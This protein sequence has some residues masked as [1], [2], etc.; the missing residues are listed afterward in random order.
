MKNRRVSLTLGFGIEEL[1]LDK[2]A[3]HRLD[4]SHCGRVGQHAVVQR[5]DA[6]E[7]NGHWDL[8]LG[9]N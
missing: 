9:F 3:W 4:H 8:S 1:E 5:E 2:D 6:T 7:R